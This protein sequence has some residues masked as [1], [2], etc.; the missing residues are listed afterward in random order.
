M[1][2]SNRPCTAAVV[3]TLMTL[4]GC[5]TQ[6]PSPGVVARGGDRPTT[7]QSLAYVAAEYT[8]APSSA[9]SESDAVEEFSKEGV[10]TELRY[11]SDGEYDGEM[12][13]VAVGTGLD[14]PAFDCDSKATDYL[15]GCVDYEDGSTLMWEDVA[16]EEDPGVVY[17]VVPKGDAHV[18]MFYA[19]PAIKGDPRSLDMAISVDDLFAIANDPRVDVTT[20][21]V[22]LDAAEELPF[23]EE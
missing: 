2:R 3:L 12:L 8:A 14:K 17:V 15:A 20:S 10:G 6:A 9:V 13:V 1:I 7:A 16:P 23:W 5:G 19:G 22:A 21:Q 18:L 11:G 4:T